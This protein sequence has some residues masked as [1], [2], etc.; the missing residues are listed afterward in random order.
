[1][2]E[3]TGIEITQQEWNKIWNNILECDKCLHKGEFL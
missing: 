2:G 3:D 1:M